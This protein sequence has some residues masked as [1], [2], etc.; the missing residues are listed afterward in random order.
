MNL[1]AGDIG[2]TKTSL[3]IV[4]PTQ[5][6]AQPLAEATLPSRQFTSLAALVQ[7]FLSEVTIPVQR[8]CFGVAGPVVDG[9]ATITNL[10]WKMD[11]AQLQS[12]LKLERVRLIND[13]VAVANAVPHLGASDLFTLNRGRTDPTGPIA[14]VAP[15]TGLGEAYLVHNGAR[16]VAYPSEGGHA[17]FAPSN[18]FEMGLLRHLSQRFGHVSWE[19]VCSGIGIP[20][21]YEYLKVIGFEHEPNWLAAKLAVADDHT[22]I[23]MQAA[24][25]EDPPCKLCRATLNTFVALLGAEAGNMALKV[26]ATGGVYLG[27]G[28]PP[29]ILA[30][31]QEGHFMDAF[32]HKGRMGEILAQAPVHVI[33]NPQAA[34]FGA[35]YFGLDD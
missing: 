13:L 5:G 16:Y 12:S 8:A 2:G 32:V 31:L 21:I 28:I 4:D 26:L 7:A 25:N 9:R 30:S 14:V 22:P 18:E 35:A 6:P 34:L 15:G 33:L 23:I 19:R 24:L 3:A 11:E 17:S 1:L 27:G 20:N 10:P 29:R